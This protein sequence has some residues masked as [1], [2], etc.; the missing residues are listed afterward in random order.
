[1]KIVPLEINKELDGGWGQYVIIE[2]KGPTLELERSLSSLL[3]EYEEEEKDEKNC[4]EFCRI[5]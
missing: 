2:H 5:S 1:M 4:N 3:E